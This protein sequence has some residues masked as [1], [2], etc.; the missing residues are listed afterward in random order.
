V[1]LGKYGLVVAGVLGGSWLALW[2]I[3]GRVDPRARVAALVGAALAAANTLVAYGIV[4]WSARRST[5]VFLGAVLGGMVGR[6]GLMLAAVVAAILLLDLPKVP[7]A[8][9]LLGYFV[10]FLVF[11]LAVLQKRTSLGSEA[12]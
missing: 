9:A 4:V 8:I 11:E 12:R 1:S 5:N 10:V 6:M 3:L 7:L 2:P